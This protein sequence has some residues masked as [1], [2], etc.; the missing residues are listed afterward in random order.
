MSDLPIL[1]SVPILGD[2]A[3]V[4]VA[5]VHPANPPTVYQAFMASLIGSLPLFLERSPVKR[6]FPVQALPNHIDEARNEASKAFLEEDDPSTYLYFADTDMEWSPEEFAR[7]VD[8]AGR[9]DRDVVGGMYFRLTAQGAAP[10]GQC[11]REDAAY[12][13]K[14]VLPMDYVGGG[15]MLIHRR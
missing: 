9:A 4:T 1:G 11:Q 14:M 2:R 15:S 6:I 7:F 12:K 13:Q 10:V 8:R 5:Y 3:S